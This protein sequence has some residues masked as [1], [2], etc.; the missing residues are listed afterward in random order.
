[1][2]LV[3]SIIVAVALFAAAGP[4]TDAYG[5]PQLEWPLRGVAFAGLGQSIMM[6]Y[7]SA[8][9]GLGQ[10]AVNLRVFFFESLIEAAATAGLVLAGAGVIGATFGRAIG[11][12]AGALI[13]VVVVARMFGRRAFVR[14]PQ[15]GSAQTIIR[16]AI[17]IF[18]TNGAYTLYA[19]ID[20][21]LVGAVLG[22]TAAGLFSA[23]LRIV[24][25]LS[26]VGQALA[27][28]VAP[29]QARSSSQESNVAAFQ[30]SLRWIF[31]FQS[32]LLAPIIVWP[33]PIVHLLL[34][35][36]FDRSANV[37][38]FLSLFIF[39]RGIGPLITTTV[40]YLGR[41]RQRIPIILG[42]LLVNVV[43]DLTLLPR[44]GVV[45]AAIGAGV[46]DLIYVPAHFLI[47]RRELAL[48]SRK[49]VVTLLRA[50]LA[51]AAAGLVL[52]SVGTNTLSIGDWVL[53]GAGGVAALT[54]VLVLSGELTREERGAVLLLL[55]FGRR[56]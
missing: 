46:A 43:V 28:S 34:G 26:Y 1:L 41:A 18:F 21:L 25:P 44:I 31:V 14:Q 11:Y 9:I 37:L 42:S 4:I 45:G 35:A 6:L 50:L 17:P 29:R 20:T 2:K 7:V 16:Y 40:N 12:A 33:R 36:Q 53:G 19:Q 24:I 27:N 49:L 5:H 48:A 38:R 3:T 23:P 8:F 47:C 55:R 52:L 15:A 56:A 51:A 32:A 22:T 54:T 39:L 10:L 30:A 13:T